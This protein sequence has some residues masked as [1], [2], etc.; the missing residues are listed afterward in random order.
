MSRPSRVSEEQADEVVRAGGVVNWVIGREGEAE[1]VGRPC[2]E[3]VGTRYGRLNENRFAV[4]SNS[5]TR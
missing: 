1:G 2:L 5:A 3:E 4:A